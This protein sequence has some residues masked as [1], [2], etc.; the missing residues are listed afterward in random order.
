MSPGFEPLAAGLR[1]QATPMPATASALPDFGA[2]PP[3]A[4]AA[5]DDRLRD[6]YEE[7]RRAGLEEARRAREDRAAE[8]LDAIRAR[9]ADAEAAASAAAE[10]AAGALASAVFAFADAALP[11]AARRAAPVLVSAFAASL[12][13]DFAGRPEAT[14]HVAPSL[15]PLLA[16]VLPL[17]VEGDLGIPEGDARITWRGGSVALDLESRRA[18]LREALSLCGLTEDPA[19]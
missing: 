13:Q 7:G 15:V 16:R 17:R 14:A 2:Q 6:A 9:L 5:E 19:P 11:G 4:A 18:A 10:G 8:A 3:P 1:P 12:R